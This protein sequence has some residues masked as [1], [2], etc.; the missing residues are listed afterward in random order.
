MDIWRARS[1]LCALLGFLFL[2]AITSQDLLAQ[3]QKP[4]PPAAVDK[5]KP[6]DGDFDVNAV[7]KRWDL[8]Y[9]PVQFEPLA[10][11]KFDRK[12]DHLEFSAN[13]ELLHAVYFAEAKHLLYQAKDGKLL[14]TIEYG[15][16]PLT[17]AAISPDG[18][19]LVATLADKGCGVYD[20]AA[21]KEVY[22]HDTITKATRIHTTTGKETYL[23]ASQ[24]AGTVFRFPLLGGKGVKIPQPGKEREDLPAAA[25]T[26]LAS[27]SD[28]TH[29]VITYPFP[30]GR[31]FVLEF[32]ADGTIKD[33]RGL[34]SQARSNGVVA[35]GNRRLGYALAPGQFYY[36]RIFD[37]SEGISFATY[38][39]SAPLIPQVSLSPDDNFSA[40]YEAVPGVLTL[41]HFT[42]LG[43]R[44]YRFR[45]SYK[46]EYVRVN[47]PQERL[48]LCDA[49]GNV[50]LSHFRGYHTPEE[51]VET[52]VQSWLENKQ[53]ERVDKMA[54]A[55]E[56]DCSHFVGSPASTSKYLLMFYALTVSSKSLRTIKGDNK[57]LDGWLERN[58]DSRMARFIRLDRAVSAAWQARGTG[59]ANTVTERGRDGFQTNLQKAEGIID[60]LA[61]EPTI[62][63]R[64]YAA[65]FDTAKGLGWEADKIATYVD[66]MFKECPD[67]FTGHAAYADSLLP[68]WGGAPDDC[69]KYADRVLKEI[70]G[71][72]GE[73]VY[74]AI[75]LKLANYHSRGVFDDLGL[76]KK[77]TLDG[78]KHLYKNQLDTPHYR[79][80]EMF[81][82]VLCS[83]HER[84]LVWRK[85]I[86]KH[87][88]VWAQGVTTEAYY[89]RLMRPIDG[90]E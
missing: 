11:W 68:R 36:A 10:N 79:Q 84:Y 29:L 60:L 71:P 42:S 63:P 62:P 65:I 4:Q 12:P 86:M 19:H 25:R 52:D 56:K 74:T 45:G 33:E 59:F 9:E 23:V 2:S 22:T 40:L 20:I 57:H 16:A 31:L 47:W 49:E 1:L 24:S 61:K 50:Q 90:D 82:S 55:L 48:A 8:P 7:L 66:R 32:N 69:K 89:E 78:V 85:E 88:D 46:P 58:P 43:N 3:E 54:L 34:S 53:D 72:T 41:R 80:T 37:K 14:E 70:P 15:T 87:H 27:S 64:A 44:G 39:L 75:V 81:A 30:V 5:E 38:R 26:E 17:A 6:A 28:G 21:K 18:K 67:N 83:D 51:F 76:D 77:A 73:A 35:V 13:G